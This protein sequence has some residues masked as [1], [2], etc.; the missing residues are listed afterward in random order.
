MN[1]YQK[2]DFKDNFEKVLLWMPTFRQSYNKELSEDYINNET[3]LPLFNSYDSMK[4]MN[5]F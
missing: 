1:Y 5:D 2:N 3:G 4:L